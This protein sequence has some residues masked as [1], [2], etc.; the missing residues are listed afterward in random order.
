MYNSFS[1]QVCGSDWIW[2]FVF[3][4]VFV[5]VFVFVFVS[6]GSQQAQWRSSRVTFATND[7]N[8]CCG[9]WKKLLS[10]CVLHNY[11]CWRG[12]SWRTHNCRRSLFVESPVWP[13]GSTWKH[14]NPSSWNVRLWFWP[15]NCSFSLFWG[16]KVLDI[17]LKMKMRCV[18]YEVDNSPVGEWLE[19]LESC[20][21]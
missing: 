17:S 10:C 2:T 3:L 18:I 8:T 16:G 14:S 6:G 9:L 7:Y 12:T 11:R 15:T 5:Y 1:Q 20:L 21:K 4:F 19:I 13:H